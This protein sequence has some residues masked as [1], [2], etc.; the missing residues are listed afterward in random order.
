MSQRNKRMISRRAALTALG[1]GAAAA[2][3][4]PELRSVRA[5]PLAKAKYFI[6]V[7]MP[8]GMSR[9]FWVPKPGFDI[10]YD[11]SVLQPFDDATKYG[12]SFRD[13]IVALE[14]LDLSAGIRSATTGHDG[15]R[16]ILTGSGG[17]GRNASID[18]FLAVEQG[19]GQT[20]P[21]P[22][23]VLG[24][25]LE[26]AKLDWCISYAKGGIGMPKVVSPLA[27]FNQAFGQWLLG[28]DPEAVARAAR[29]QRLGKSLLDYWTQDLAALSARAPQSERDKLDQ[30]ATALRDLERRVLGQSVACTAPAQPDATQ[31]PSLLA[32][33]GGEPYFEVITN[34]QIDLMVHALSCDVTRFSTLFLADLSRTHFDPAL[35]E[36][37]HTD[38]AHRYSTAGRSG[39]GGNVMSQ[40]QLARQNRYSYG[41][42]ARIL[43]R[44]SEASLLDQT[45]LVAMSD[46]G[47]PAKHSSRQIPTLLAGGWGGALRAGRHIDLGPDGVPNN[48]LLVSV[49]QAF[50]VE[51]NAYGQSN[52]ASILSGALDLS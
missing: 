5:A 10:S 52:D 2:L 45:V 30:H 51:S 20:T 34:L 26:E 13:R 25:G 17:N 42:V 22:S 27:T 37:V 36:D 4:F 3:A 32:Y 48:Q 6:G 12:Q 15:S 14:G 39:I 11:N 47:D 23:L 19:L 7:Y 35:P 16:V 9:E 38:V 21:V 29:E 33:Q 43:Q 8:H 24:V 18:Q 44:L 1:A 50:G 41:K 40:Q 46:M 28:S 49:Q 31:F